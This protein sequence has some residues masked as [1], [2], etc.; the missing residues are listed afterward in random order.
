MYLREGAQIKKVLLINP[1]RRGENTG[2]AWPHLG[3]TILATILKNSG[4]VP[5]VVCYSYAQDAPDVEYFVREFDPDVVGVT[6]WTSCVDEARRIIDNILG[7]KTIPIIV[8]GPHATLYCQDLVSDMPISYIV[9]GEAEEIIADV[10]RHA[11]VQQQPVVVHSPVPDVTRLPFPD[12]RLCYNYEEMTVKPI[13]LSR[14]CPFNCSFCE[15][16]KL[17]GRKARLREIG[18]CIEEI[19]EGKAMLPSVKQI[20]IVDDAP[21]TRL[22]RFIDFLKMYIDAG[23]KL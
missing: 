11:E 10:V 3:L 13:Q 15:V 6:M 8:G 16:S 5:L 22:D 1:R 9:T 20:R 12:F 17:F 7:V 19:L 18:P 23:L 2:S 4:F 14:G 21:T